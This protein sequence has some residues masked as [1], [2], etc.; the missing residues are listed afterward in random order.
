MEVTLTKSA[1][2]DDIVAAE[3]EEEAVAGRVG[4][5]DEHDNGDA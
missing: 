1:A 3:A 2:F 5:D 4:A